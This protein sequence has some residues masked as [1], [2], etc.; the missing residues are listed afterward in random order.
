MKKKSSLTTRA[1]LDGAQLAWGRTE[2]VTVQDMEGNPIEITVRAGMPLG[3]MFE[4]ISEAVTILVSDGQYMALSGDQIMAPVILDTLTDLPMP[5]DMDQ[6]ELDQCYELVF[7]YDGIVNRLDP[8]GPAS[9]L[10]RQM[11]RYTADLAERLMTYPER[12]DS[13]DEDD[14]DSIMD[15][16]DFRNMR[17]N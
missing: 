2:T 5:D 15:L 3:E 10:I 16:S 12:F 11:R 1:A 14:F 7:G 13:D 6:I 4:I 17:K 8:D 9:F